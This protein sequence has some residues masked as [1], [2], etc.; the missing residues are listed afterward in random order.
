MIP[1]VYLLCGLTSLA[2]AI[3]LLSGYSRRRSR[4]LLWSGL[5]FIGLAINNMLLCLDMLV[6]TDV[7]F[8]IWRT[9]AALAGAVILVYG[10]IWEMV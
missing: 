2:C 3:C 4:I 8:L 1:I 6:F 10:F 5:C 7:S 9:S